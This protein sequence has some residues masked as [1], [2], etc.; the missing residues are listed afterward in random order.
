MTPRIHEE[1][2]VSVR[3]VL[4]W[5]AASVSLVIVVAL[6]MVLWLSFAGPHQ[7]LAGPNA[8]GRSF[9]IPIGLC[10]L[11]MAIAVVAISTA[12]AVVSLVRRRRSRPVI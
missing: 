2:P 10:L 5:I 8:T 4:F 6:S 3:R 7:E 1:Q 9:V 11:L 12:W